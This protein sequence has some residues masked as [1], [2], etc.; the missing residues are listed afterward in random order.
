M[1][2]FYRL[3][4]M[5]KLHKYLSHEVL[6]EVDRLCEMASDKESPMFAEFQA[7]IPDNEPGERETRTEAIKAIRKMV[8]GALVKGGRMD[9]K[10]IALPGYVPLENHVSK[11]LLEELQ[12]LCW[13]AIDPDSPFYGP[14]EMLIPNTYEGELDKRR[15]AI[16]SIGV[17]AK[18]ARKRCGGG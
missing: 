13:L 9:G 18:E 2:E 4:K 7:F 16:K 6:E 14:M 17:V 5:V 15:M 3:P 10:H 1:T 11:M 12:R 8:K